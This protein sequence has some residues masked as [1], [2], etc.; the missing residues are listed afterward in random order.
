[1][2]TARQSSAP[3]FIDVHVHLNGDEGIDTFVSAGIVAVRNAGMRVNAERLNRPATPVIV[4]S[5]WAIYKRGGYGARF[6][7]AVDTKSEI[8]AE[9][10]RLKKAGADIIKVM[11]S[12]IVSLKNPGAVT[13]GGF[14]RDELAFIVEEAAGLGLGVMAHANGEAVTA[15]AE[16][17]VRSIEH[18]FF[19]TPRAL[20]VMA[21]KAVYWVPTV[22]ALVRA[23]ERNDTPMRTKE[24]IL[25]LVDAQ[26]GLL[27]HG[28]T[29]GVPLA[30]GTD[31]LLP[32][33]GYPEAY[34]SELS[35][36]ERAGIPR[37]AVMKIA[38]EGGARLLG[39]AK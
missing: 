39:I 18:G 25:D 36:F 1:M 11:A 5:C 14:D 28:Y 15:A 32:D 29:I 20:E 23:T 8:K 12:G 31:C 16:A 24:F 6:G 9:I 21:K 30:V 22:G 19:M 27:Q 13:P 38:C 7:A 4:T 3:G 17:G 10:Q 34:R 37:D 33:A 26:L 2:Q 35:Y